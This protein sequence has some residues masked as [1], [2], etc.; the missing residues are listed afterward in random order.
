MNNLTPA[1]PRD[2]ASL[3]DGDLQFIGVDERTVFS[4]AGFVYSARNCRF[5]YK[6]AAQRD[7]IRIL[8]FGLGTD[9]L[10]PFANPLGATVF[11]DPVSRVEWILIATTAGVYRTR[12][13]ALAMPVPLPAGVTLTKGTF[14]RFINALG[15][16]VLLRGLGPSGTG[17]DS[18]GNPLTPLICRDLL[19]GFVVVAQENQFS[20]TLDAATNLVTLA[21]HNLVLG[22]PLQFTAPAVPQFPNPDLVYHLP[23]AITAGQ[24]YYVVG[25]PNANT[26]AISATPGGAAVTWNTSPTDAIVYA[27]TVTLLDGAIPIPPAQDGL[28]AQNRLFLIDGLDTTLASDIGDYTRYQPA[29][30]E[31]TINQGDAYALRY[32][33]LFNESTMLFF[34]SGLVAKATGVTGDLSGAVGPLNVTQAY[35]LAAPSVADI[36]TDVYWLNSELRLTSLQ[37]TELNKEQGTDQALSDPLLRTFGRINPGAAGAARLAT[38]DSYLFVALPLDDARLLDPRDLVAANWTGGTASL[39]PAYDGS[40]NYTLT[41]LTASSSY[42]YTDAANDTGLVNGTETLPGAAPFTA[43]GTSVTLTGTPGALVTAIVQAVTGSNVNT[44]IAVYD[45]IN[46]AWAGTDEGAPGTNVV[47]W[48]KFTYNGSPVLG[49]LGADGYLHLHNTGYED[50]QV[51]PFAAPYVDIEV[52]ALPGNGDEVFVSAAPPTPGQ[53]QATASANT[54]GWDCS[55]LANAQ[56]TLATALQATATGNLVITPIVGGARVEMPAY[57]NAGL[58]YPA[59]LPH[60]VFSGPDQNWYYLDAHGPRAIQPVGPPTY[61][62]TRAY[63]C[64]SWASYALIYTTGGRLDFKRYTAATLHLAGW[65]PN[66]TINTRTNGIGD[67]TGYETGPMPNPLKYYTHDTADWDP[68]NTQD[69]FNAPNRQDYA[70]GFTGG[71]LELRSGVDLDALQEATQRVPVNERALYLQIELANT[72]GRLELVALAMEAQEGETIAGVA[73]KG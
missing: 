15:A 49:S 66:Y 23:A 58:N 47:D 54:G 34:K 37:L 36:G 32:L 52:I 26:F 11:L 2:E 71:G 14:T 8:P 35:G 5:R 42:Q 29:T 59:V 31:F 13:G 43:Q 53:G 70:Y 68:T 48:I 20:V 7:G 69:D 39:G 24:T 30:A 60:V 22:D 28:F 6:R 33:Y 19:T 72:A 1:G 17:F 46:A 56:A 57:Q 10:S 21:A 9:G 25:T 55:S 41:G 62:L 64:R 65:A 44:A 73:V 18:A 63:P 50:E 12:P 16:V 51:L 27:G 61:L 67:L 38:F 3:P 40:G 45:F 4:P